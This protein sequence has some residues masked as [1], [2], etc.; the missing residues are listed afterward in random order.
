M[1]ELTRVDPSEV[2]RRENYIREYQRPRSLRDPFTWNWPYRAAGAAVVI[3]AGAAHLHNLWLR[4]PWHY[5]LYGRI[6][7]IAGAGLIAYSLGVL[8]EHH[9]RTRDAVT[10]HYKSLHPDDFS[11]L[12]DI[13]G[14][15]FAQ[16]ILPWYPRR[17]QYKKND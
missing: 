2:T 9:Y 1:T 12:D 7:L 15:P 5:A 8:R 13:Y 3:S 16:I 11:A 6:G 17:P 14:R 10:E 4:K